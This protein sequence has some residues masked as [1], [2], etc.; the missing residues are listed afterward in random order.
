MVSLSRTDSTASA[1]K[2]ISLLGTFSI[3]RLEMGLSELSALSG[4]PKATVLR[5]MKSLVEGGL[6]HQDPKTRL[7]RLGYRCIELGELAKQSSDLQ[8]TAMEYMR[9]LLATTGETVHLAVLTGNLEAIYIEKVEC[10]QPLRHWTHLGQSIPLHAGAAGK[11]LGAYLPPAMQEQLCKE[12]RLER[13][14]D[15]TIVDCD[16]LMKHFREVRERGWVESCNELYTGVRTIAAPVF[17]VTGEAIA[18]IS[19]G[20]PASRFDEEKV[21]QAVP[22]LLDCVWSVSKQL[23][24]STA[25][26]GRSQAREYL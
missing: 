10:D 3:D 6:V 15:D 2:A 19:V 5:M 22:K 18:S 13:F 1:L 16:K 23:G 21:S 4:M 20:G 7:Y 25:A 26:T 14:T 12:G 17:G 24:Y 8:R 11:V 9:Q